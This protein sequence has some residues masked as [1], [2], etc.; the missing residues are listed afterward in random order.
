[1]VMLALLTL[2]AFSYARLPV[3]QMPEV[4]M[5][6]VGVSVRWPGASP[7]AVENDVIKPMENVINTVN[8]L[9]TG[10][11]ARR[12]RCQARRRCS[13]ELSHAAAAAAMAVHGRESRGCKLTPKKEAMKRKVEPKLYTLNHKP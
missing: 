12:R 11:D 9:L 8:V 6:V 3:E 1:M 13:Q 4:S 7:E 2:G 5:P 10:A